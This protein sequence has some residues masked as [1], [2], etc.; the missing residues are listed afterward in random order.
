MATFE[1]SLRP[2]L[3]YV[4][5]INDNAHQGALKIGEATA[6]LGD[7]Y[8]KPNSSLLNKAAKER[9][10]QYTKTAGISYQLLYTEGTM[11]TDSKGHVSSFNDKQVH[12]VL[13]RSGIKRKSFEKKNQGREWYVTDLKT[14]KRAIAAVKEGRESLDNGEVKYILPVYGAGLWGPIWGYVAVN[15]DGTTIYGAYF[16]HQGE[17]PGLGAEIAKP[18]FQVQFE[19]KE[20]YKDGEFRAIDVMKA[21]QKPADNADY[22]NAISGGTVTSKGVEAMLKSCLSDYSAFLNQ[23]KN[24][25]TK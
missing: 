1:S 23:L 19:G 20:L 24:G 7:G 6:T 4:F 16:S 17:T 12:K 2:K 15:N 13:E 3:I 9:I 5:R 25:K 11:F 22:V 18:E 10:D 14:V 21:G 8:F